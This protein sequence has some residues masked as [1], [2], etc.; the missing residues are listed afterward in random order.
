MWIAESQ[1]LQETERIVG[2]SINFLPLK[3][4]SNIVEGN[5]LRL[6]WNNVIPASELNFIMGNPPFVG[7]DWMS[8]GQH[9]DM[10]YFFKKTGRLDYVTAWYVKSAQFIH[11]N[12]KCAFVSTNSITQGV[13]APS[14]WNR[15]NEFNIHIIFGYRTFI[16]DSE[17]SIKAHVHCV[18]IGFSKTNIEN[19]KLLVDENNKKEFVQEISPYLRKESNT[20][21][22][23]RIKPFDDVPKMV[24]G[25]MPKDGGGFILEKDEFE[26]IKL[27]DPYALKFIRRYMMGKEFIN[28]IER[29]CFWFKG[30]DPSEIS[31]SKYALEHIAKVKKY[32]EC[33]SAKSTRKLAFERPLLFAQISQ[34]QEKRFIAVPKVSSCARRYIPIGYL[35]PSVIVGDKLFIVPDG[36]L[37]HFGVLTSIVHNAWMRKVAGRL[38]SD[39]S[40]TTTVVYNTFV[41]P[42]IT[43]EGRKYIEETAQNILN[44][45]N[46][47]IDLS[48]ADLYGKNYFIYNDLVKA[49][50]AN[51]EAVIAAYG[52]NKDIKEKE[53]VTNLI[54]M[55]TKKIADLDAK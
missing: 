2:H 19:N 10:K 5:A 40:Y 22:M 42:N 15:L 49:H 28:N 41:W 38:K 36:D 7:Y 47:Y 33:S 24:L 8:K 34:P 3:T 4:Y 50:Q 9:D 25:N 37:Y 30:I 52:W 54:L 55:Y 16:W 11:D 18:I 43:H 20:I 45:R 29:Y 21:V 44:V 53:I 13:Q 26:E 46:K 17:A 14:L 12:T 35:D 32:R 48:L 31:K 51:D 27:K 23:P 39:Y 1:L 6:D